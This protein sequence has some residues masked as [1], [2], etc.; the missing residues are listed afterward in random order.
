MRVGAS[1]RGESVPHVLVAVLQSEPAWSRLPQQ[2]YPRLKLL[3][4]RI[5]PRPQ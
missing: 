4:E 5:A 2:L 3:L 1:S